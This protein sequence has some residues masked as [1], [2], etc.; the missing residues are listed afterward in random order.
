[1]VST[2]L[3]IDRE[4]GVLIDFNTGK[5]CLDPTAKQGFTIKDRSAQKNGT[6]WWYALIQLE[7]LILLIAAI[8]NPI[9]KS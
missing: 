4:D 1:M 9:K 2:R 7:L 6:C 8:S 3:E 5:F